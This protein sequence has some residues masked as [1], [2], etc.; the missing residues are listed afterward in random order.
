MAELENSSLKNKLDGI[1]K[2]VSKF[3]KGRENLPRIVENS[4]SIS[5][6]HGLGY[7]KKVKKSQSSNLNKVKSNKTPTSLNRLVSNTISIWIP[8]TN[9][10]LIRKKYI[11]SFIEDVHNNKNYIYKRDTKPTWVWFPK[12]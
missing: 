2:N 12:T 5:N 9:N 4:Q 10:K 11:S 7:K 1:T 6:K 8:K 3:N